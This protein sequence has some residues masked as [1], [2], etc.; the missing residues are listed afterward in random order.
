MTIIDAA[1]F[2]VY[3]I[4]ECLL[5]MKSTT[6]HSKKISPR[7]SIGKKFHLLEVLA[8]AQESLELLPPSVLTTSLLVTS[9]TRLGKSLVIEFVY[10]RF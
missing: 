10:G 3:S 8:A 1:P 9:S 6:K 4:P 5:L 7:K 2:L